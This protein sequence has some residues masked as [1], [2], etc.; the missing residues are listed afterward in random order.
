MLTSRSRHRGNRRK[1][2]DI[3]ASRISEN[4]CCR[5]SSGARRTQTVT[6]RN[7]LRIRRLWVQVLP[8]APPEPL[9][10][11]GFRRVEVHAQLASCILGAILG[12]HLRLLGPG[13]G[14]TLPGSTGSGRVS[15]A[16]DGGESLTNL[17]AASPE[18]GPRSSVPDSAVRGVGALPALG[19][20]ACH[21]AGAGRNDSPSP[22]A[23]CGVPRWLL[24]RLRDS[25]CAPQHD[26]PGHVWATAWKPA[27]LPYNAAQ[28][29]RWEPSWEPFAVDCC[30]RVWTAM[31]M[32]AF[33]SRLC[34]LPWTPTDAAWRFTDQKVVDSSPA[35]VQ[36][37]TL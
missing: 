24:R 10:E 33:R 11:Q 5:F 23:G 37:K 1:P 3:T 36:E 28:H 9:C 7:G 35:S 20:C 26:V 29:P 19:A 25:F 16:G 34:G 2:G 31:A 17:W 6:A 15:E 8:G 14:G 27:S 13:S 32:E 21:H 18:R 4:P 30:G 12:S 22:L